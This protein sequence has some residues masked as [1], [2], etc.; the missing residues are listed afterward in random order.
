MANLPV[1]TFNTAVLTPEI[2]AI[3][4]GSSLQARFR[5]E[6]LDNT[7][8]SKGYLNCVVEGGSV[9]S[10]YLADIKRKCS[11][12]VGEYGNYFN[13][14][15][16]T[17]RVKIYYEIFSSYSGAWLSFPLGVYVLSSGIKGIDKKIITRSVDGFDLTQVLKRKKHLSRFVVPVG[18]DPIVYVRNLL[19]DAG[20]DHDIMDNPDPVGDL[21]SA[22]RSYDP[23]SEYIATINDLLAMINYRSL[24][25]DNNGFAT[26]APYVSPQDRLVEIGYVTDDASI[27]AEGASLEFNVF[28]VPNV[29]QVVVSQPDKPV[30]IGIARN[31][32]PDSPTSTVSTAEERVYVSTDSEDL[33]SQDQATARAYRILTEQS[34]IYETIQF[35]S[36]IMPL[37]GEN[38]IL[39][40]TY[41]DLRISDMYSEIEWRIPL[42]AGEL[43]THTA[44]RLVTI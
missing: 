43:M 17:D 39:G 3:L 23:G 4:Y 40:I 25:F 37:H 20:L 28:D 2:E 38:T 16:L 8:N 5:Y 27:T 1:L 7:N 11:F 19:I 6:L 31:E 36:G 34:Q 42:R 21:T 18:S 24:Y 26:S 30:I 22:E 44:R 15:F 14:N 35:S 33:T 13:I 32:N 12:T 10:N 29:I 9:D 41:E